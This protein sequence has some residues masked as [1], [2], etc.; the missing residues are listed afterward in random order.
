MVAMA[1][2]YSRAAR[3]S[4]DQ[5]YTYLAV[6]MGAGLVPGLVAGFVAAAFWGNV[7]MWLSVFGGIGIIIGLVV[8]LML[9]RRSKRARARAKDEDR[10]AAEPS[11]QL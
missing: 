8:S 11:A 4:L 1:T 10:E 5:E 6:G 3:T 7:A 9:Y 2:D